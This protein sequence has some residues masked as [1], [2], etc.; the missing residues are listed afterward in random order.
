MSPF[1][2]CLFVFFDNPPRRVLAFQVDLVDALTIPP[3]TLH[4]ASHSL[5]DPRNRLL[6]HDDSLK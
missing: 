4:H 1:A 6:I 3:S 5:N 2:T